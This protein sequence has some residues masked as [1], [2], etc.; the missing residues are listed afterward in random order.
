M[1]A[2]IICACPSATAVSEEAAM[3]VGELKPCPFCGNEDIT[4]DYCTTR[5][6]CKKCFASSGLIS[7]YKKD[8]MTDKEAAAAAWNTRSYD[9]RNK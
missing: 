9:G 3:T 5:V 8:G 6:R 4:V 2:S 7:M 1:M